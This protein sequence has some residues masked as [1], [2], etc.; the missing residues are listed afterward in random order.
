MSFTNLPFAS[1]RDVTEASVATLSL[2]LLMAFPSHMSFLNYFKKESDYLPQRR[3]RGALSWYYVR[4]KV[5]W[6]MIF[7]M[8]GS[9]ALALGSRETKL[10]N[11][12]IGYIHSMKDMPNMLMSFLSC[13]PVLILTQVFG[14]APLARTILPVISEMV[15]LFF[16]LD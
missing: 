3:S 13:L 10:T 16:S 2:I 1:S 7:L 8:G 12:I 9:R 14:N 11:G 15:R 6:R 5:P 4:A